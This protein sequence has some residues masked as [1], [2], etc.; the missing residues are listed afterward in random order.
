M[1]SNRKFPVGQKKRWQYQRRN[2]KWKHGL[3]FFD[4]FHHLF[5]GRL[6]P[7]FVFER[8]CYMQLEKKLA[9]HTQ[10]VPWATKRILKSQQIACR[11]ATW[12]SANVPFQACSSLSKEATT[13]PS[14][15]WSNHV[16]QS[17]PCQNLWSCPGKHFTHPTSLPKCTHKYCKS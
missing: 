4:H 2:G 5:T 15:L 11:I 9:D 3:R 14:R 6:C 8:S 12:W 17:L 16:Q 10:G 13:I 7:A 1:K